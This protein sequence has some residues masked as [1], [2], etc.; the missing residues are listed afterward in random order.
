MHV[1]VAVIILRQGKQCIIGYS[2]AVAVVDIK[3]H[4]CFSDCHN[5]MSRQA[6][7][8]WFLCSGGRG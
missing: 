6:E 7:Y 4:T 3:L 1:S 2:I 5:F 8:N